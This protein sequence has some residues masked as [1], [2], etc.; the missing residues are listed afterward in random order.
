[1]SQTP[2]ATPLSGISFN[3]DISNTFT[4]GFTADASSN[5][6]FS[7]A[8]VVSSPTNGSVVISGLDA[9]Y[10]PNANFNGVDSF[11]YT[12]TDQANE[13][14]EAATVSFTVSPVNDLVEGDVTITG[15]TTEG[16]TLT[17]T[18]NLSDVEGV[19][20]LAYQWSSDGVA[21]SG[22]TGST[23]VLQHTD[24]GNVV[25]CTVSYTDGSGNSE[26]KASSATA[27]IVNVAPTAVGTMPAVNV[28]E[29][30][31]NVIINLSQYF[32]HPEAA[33]D[34]LGYSTTDA[35][36]SL[37]TSSITDSSMTLTFLANQ[38]GITSYVVNAADAQGTTA[39]QSF[40]V[41]V[42]S[43]NDPPTFN[44]TLNDV[45]K[46]ENDSAFV[47]DLTGSFS[48]V[49]HESV[50]FSVASSDTS[51]VTVSLVDASL[52]LTP[53]TDA[54]GDVDINITATDPSNGTTTQ[55]P[56]FKVVVTSSA[57]QIAALG[58]DISNSDVTSGLFL[59]VNGVKALSEAQIQSLTLSQVN[60]LNT[61]Q[62][63]Y[64]DNS[65]VAFFNSN[66]SEMT[67][68]VHGA[69]AYPAS[70]STFLNGQALFFSDAVIAAQSSSNIK[71]FNK[72]TL[73]ALTVGNLKALNSSQLSSFT[74]EQIPYI[75]APVIAGLA[76]VDSTGVVT[77]F[78]TT[79]SDRFRDALEQLTGEQLAA[80][81]ATQVA[82][83]SAAGR[84]KWLDTAQLGS[85]Q[86]EHF[87]EIVVGQFTDFTSTQFAGGFD[88][89]NIQLMTAGQFEAL[90]STTENLLNL[91]TTAQIQ[92][93]PA[94]HFSLVTADHVVRLG[95]S[96]DKLNLLTEAQISQLVPASA[97]I[98]ASITTTQIA[99]LS[100]VVIDDIS[101]AFYTNLTAAQRNA[102]TSQQI[103]LL[104]DSVVGSLSAAQIGDLSG[105]VINTFTTSQLQSLSTELQVQAISVVDLSDIANDLS[106]SQIQ[107]LSTA[108]VEVLLESQISSLSE[109]ER[110]S[111]MST[112]QLSAVTEVQFDD[113]APGNDVSG[114]FHE[115]SA[116]Q[117]AAFDVSALSVMTQSQFDVLD[118]T[119]VN[120]ISGLSEQQIQ[121]IPSSNFGSAT[122]EHLSRFDD[123]FKF[124]KYSQ[125]T[126]LSGTVINT[127]LT[128][129]QIEG[130]DTVASSLVFSNL[131]V[132]DVSEFDASF[133][134]Q[135]TE[136]QV[137]DISSVSFSG[138]ANTDISNFDAS[139]VGY[140]DASQVQVF[141][142]G[143]DSQTKHLAVNNL[144]T[145]LHLSDIQI[146]DL[147]TSQ[148]SSFSGEKIVQLSSGNKLTL[149]DS[150]QITGITSVQTSSISA[151]QIT[152]LSG[153]V[154]IANLPVDVV[155]QLSATQLHALAEDTAHLPLDASSNLSI[156][157]AQIQ[158]LSGSANIVHLTVSQIQ[159]LNV[160][161]IQS[162]SLSQIQLIIATQGF[163]FLKSQMK[164]FTIVDQIQDTTDLSGIIHDFPTFSISQLEGLNLEQLNFLL[165][166]NTS[167]YISL[168]QEQ[169]DAVTTSFASLDYTELQVV[170]N[171]KIL[172]L[173]PDQLL[174]VTSSQAANVIGNLTQSQ[175][176]NLGRNIR[177]LNATELSGVNVALI[178]ESYD[179]AYTN[180][181][182]EEPFVK[183]LSDLS[184]DQL[185]AI[186][187]TMVT[188]LMNSRMTLLSD[189]IIDGLSSSS[190]GALA[191]TSMTDSQF[192][193][194]TTDSI[195]S[196]SPTQ[197]GVLDA[198]NILQLGAT[199][200]SIPD[201]AIS[202]LNVNIIQY[203]TASSITEAQ[204]NN[205]TALQIAEFTDEQ[206]AL[207]TTGVRSILSN[208]AG[209][210]FTTTPLEF[211]LE[212][213][214][215]SVD[216][217]SMQVTISNEDVSQNFLY[218]ATVQ[219]Y[220]NLS[221][222]K[223]MFLYRYSNESEVR[224]YVDK[225]NF[226]VNFNY[227]EC[228]HLDLVDND[229]IIGNHQIAYTDTVVDNSSVAYFSD[230]ASYGNMGFVGNVVTNSIVGDSR[231]PFSWDYIHYTAKE[232]LGVFSAYPLFNQIRTIEENLRKNINDSINGQMV[233]IIES[234][235][236]SSGTGRQD[237]NL[238]PVDV[239]NLNGTDGS[240]ATP[241]DQA[242]I[243][244]VT[245]ARHIVF[246]NEDPSNDEI[247][248][249]IFRTLL[250]QRKP[251]FNQAEEQEIAYGFPFR[252][253][254]SMSF[255]VEMKPN[256][257]QRKIAGVSGQ[258]IGDQISSRKYRINIKF[259]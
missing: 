78:N 133:V 218:D 207:F 64:F 103:P 255:I 102:F 8:Q 59:M 39:S 50:S 184:V 187:V 118:D 223:K 132:N 92:S 21:I 11:T 1:M 175:Q 28:D 66:I 170:S 114:Q 24:V 247:A 150:T 196:F 245:N 193:N 29:D 202:S 235:D 256:A 23:Y 36:G 70:S 221:D 164:H 116:E 239:S 2:T 240:G 88:V 84:L 154:H 224:L 182:I 178:L 115:F 31:A 232:V 216:V 48:D 157:P 143:A 82:A 215:T 38:H 171:D 32:S 126:E 212:Q 3:E 134:N 197:S 238:D 172:Y 252:L 94:S 209:F 129:S 242:V 158:D 73:E 113:I 67:Y 107:D 161:Q 57:S 231:I 9:T 128:Q 47:V 20:A 166:V 62:A 40:D 89:S 136:S 33:G 5:S 131:T 83:I 135:L 141:N 56:A 44:S 100:T 222:A 25:V 241:Y 53:V 99:D 176:L 68:D 6:P 203:I 37:V 137:N 205:F 189:A 159:S 251:D 112:T 254:D 144:S 111:L 75:P 258:S 77:D 96:P 181:I 60:N 45:T 124:V 206:N 200:A 226:K 46:I 230:D 125:F 153:A 228:D 138:F 156:T 17:A 149:L 58:D 106:D 7:S 243:D 120:L 108:Q 162:L 186:P 199:F 35:N 191:I 81:T 151:T 253:N 123:S 225:R 104:L 61:V 110:L 65:Q 163:V 201:V 190:F 119:S 140:L 71:S 236:I 91:L 233:P 211:K 192:A 22:A 130:I 18:N 14:S 195:A 147:S 257:E 155:Q 97:D 244:G 122:V 204:A 177:A 101:S 79:T 10:T 117:F 214:N 174:S 160:D 87:S 51:V 30:S 98:V 105:S 173:T 234:I 86:N 121:I 148:I 229:P 90:G 19:G 227:V 165:D 72:A 219:S 167:V 85:M 76:D 246:D 248:A 169:K 42:D 27:T 145:A 15:T 34:T 54:F 55:S 69:L 237:T 208:I 95:E 16:E 74:S 80:L 194:L 43:V 109:L 180:D 127:G 250:L 12:V 146:Q 210:D 142:T 13:V 93:I 185:A 63:G 139:F 41:T 168:S 249:T 26:S 220:M 52:T 259:I 217:A 188:D 152:D 49:D 213:L 198:S 179:T 183:A 4:L